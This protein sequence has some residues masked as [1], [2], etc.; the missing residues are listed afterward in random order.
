MND[1]QNAHGDRIMGEGVPIG[2]NDTIDRMNR[3]QSWDVPGMIADIA[4]YLRVGN[5]VP[6]GQ[7]LAALDWMTFRLRECRSVLV[8]ADS[9]LSA[10]AHGRPVDDVESQK[11]SGDARKLCELLQG[12]KSR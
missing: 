8:A 5:E 11:I 2:Y 12:F 3:P 4:E 9:E 10:V 1:E 6:A 7:L